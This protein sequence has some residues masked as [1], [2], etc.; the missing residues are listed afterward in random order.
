LKP[1]TFPTTF[2]AL[3]KADPTRPRTRSALRRFMASWLAVLSLFAAGPSLAASPELGRLFY[4]PVQRSQLE[5]ARARHV[6]QSIGQ[7]HPAPPPP[8]RYD[9]LVIRSDG[10]T[11]RWVDGKAQAGA[12]GVADLKPGQIRAG[13]K[14]YE[15]YQVLRP[16]ASTAAGPLT[17]ETAP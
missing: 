7:T 4:S 9:G 11:T 17:K 12:S 2:R 13:G 3:Q 6:T 15:P 5:S 14:V 16:T 1:N 10:Q 8:L